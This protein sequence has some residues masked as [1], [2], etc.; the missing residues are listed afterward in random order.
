M[1]KFL[2]PFQ[3]MV[4]A[5]LFSGSLA[6]WSV[7]GG[8]AHTDNFKFFFGGIQIRACGARTNCSFKFKK[9]GGGKISLAR[10]DVVARPSS[11]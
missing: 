5:D 1:K 11:S 2:F 10:P 3:N 4:Q 9:K 6:V 8:A 7:R